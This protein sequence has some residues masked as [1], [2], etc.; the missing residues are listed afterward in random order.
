MIGKILIALGLI[1]FCM[2]VYALCAINDGEDEQD[3]STEQIDRF[4]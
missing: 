1:F 2:M 4:K 3:G